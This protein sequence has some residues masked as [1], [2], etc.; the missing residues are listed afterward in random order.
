MMEASEPGTGDHRRRRRRFALH[1]PPI[2]RVLIEGIVT[3]VV[4]IVADVLANE[5]PEMPF[6]QRDDMIE[7]LASAASHPAFRNPILP[8]CL[9]TCAF[10]RRTGCLQ[11][12]NHISIEFRVVVEDGITMRNRIGKCFTQLLH[13][14]VMSGNWIVKKTG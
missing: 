13:N 11:E 4:V 6:V 3:W 2:R 7:N 8:G 9:H 1:W 12:S 5:P 14:P 10:R